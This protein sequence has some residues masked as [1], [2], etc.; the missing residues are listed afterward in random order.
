MY[1]IFIEMLK[2]AIVVADGS[3]DIEVVTPTDI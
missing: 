3:E 2:I 1:I